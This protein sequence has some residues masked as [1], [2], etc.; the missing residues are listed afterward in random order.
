MGI[1]SS[2][3]IFGIRIY[4]FNDND[5]SNILFEEKY[6]EIM[7]HEQMREVYLFYTQLQ[8]KN[9]IHFQ[10]YTECSNTLDIN[11][12][13]TIYMMWYPLSLNSFLEQFNV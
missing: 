10:F 7:S 6:E 4:T 13:E 9:N 2:G 8:N 3:S 11:N 1:Y 12:K 5:Y